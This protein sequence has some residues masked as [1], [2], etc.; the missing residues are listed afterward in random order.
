MQGRC[1]KC[2]AIAHYYP[3]KSVRLSADSAIFARLPRGCK[4]LSDQFGTTDLSVRLRSTHF[5]DYI[6]GDKRCRRALP[7]LVYRRHVIP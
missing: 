4:P 1:A 6:G 7:V 5:T 2:E 3:S